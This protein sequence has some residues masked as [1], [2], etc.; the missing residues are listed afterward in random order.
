MPT[1]RTNRRGRVG[2]LRYFNGWR[3]RGGNRGWGT[4]PHWQEV[5]GAKMH[6][7]PHRI[8]PSNYQWRC[9]VFSLVGERPVAMSHGPW[10]GSPSANF[11]GG[12]HVCFA[13]HCLPASGGPV[14]APTVPTMMPSLARRSPLST[15]DICPTAQVEMRGS[16]TD[17]FS[18]LLR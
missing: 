12:R 4:L 11:S 1:K 2:L 6:V 17:C 9:H 16:A 5:L 10:K 7:R 14:S 18:D 15:R 13:P 8:W 3:H